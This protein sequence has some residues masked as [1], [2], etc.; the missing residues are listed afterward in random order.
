MDL[1][2]GASR[3]WSRDGSG[4]PREKKDRYAHD[5]LVDRRLAPDPRHRRQ[6]RL[7]R[8]RPPRPARILGRGVPRRSRKGG[9]SRRDCP[10]RVEQ[11]VLWA[12]SMA[13]C[14]LGTRLAHAGL[15]ILTQGHGAGPHVPDPRRGKIA[16]PPIRR[17][18]VSASCRGNRQS[19]RRQVGPAPGRLREG[20]A[21]G[22]AKP[23]SGN[24]LRQ[25]GGNGASPCQR[26]IGWR[27]G[28]KRGVALTAVNVGDET[29][30]VA[31]KIPLEPGRTA[32][33]ATCLLPG[34]TR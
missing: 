19:L 28:N 1:S 14:R 34:T 17:S 23:R 9:S 29:C 21:D 8:P 11:G 30:R 4:T 16:A 13:R 18:T 26:A 15:Q 10:R 5:R 31:F 12:P 32:S 25:L 20:A 3:V 6:A 33:R 27:F 7:R 22:E 24:R 2:I